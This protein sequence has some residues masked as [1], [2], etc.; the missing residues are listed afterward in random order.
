MTCD[1]CESKVC[2]AC[3]DEHLPGW[4]K[5]SRLSKRLCPDTNKEL[6]WD[7]KRQTYVVRN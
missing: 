5:H 2:Q 1:A 6:D 3:W 4:K 7:I